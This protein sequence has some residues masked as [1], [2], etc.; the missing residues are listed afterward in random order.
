MT[1]PRPALLAAWAGA[2]A[3]GRCGAADALAAVTG[4]D[5]PHTVAV[6][7]GATPPAGLPLPDPGYLSDLL[8]L[9]AA[10]GEEAPVRVSCALPAPGDVRGVP[11]PAAVLAAAVE[12]GGCVVVDGLPD[13]AGPAGLALVPEVEEFGPEGDVG[14]HVTWRVHRT[15]RPASPV[16][17][18]V[19]EADR[20]FRSALAEA[21]DA[22]ERLDVAS[23]RDDPAAA[24]RQG[25]ATSQRLPGTLPPRALRLLTRAEHVLAILDAAA[26]DPGGTVSGWEAAERAAALAGL[27]RAARGAVVAAVSLPG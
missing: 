23:W 7:L 15:D 20:E 9:L 26:V 12:A 10:A 17:T 21:T 3:A 8:V 5:E 27:S 11:G 22:I 1:L 2:V 4:S 16:H 25:G 14:A 19:A 24:L 6:E 18:S 13:R